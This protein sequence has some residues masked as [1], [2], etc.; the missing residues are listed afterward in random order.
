MIGDDELGLA[1]PGDHSRELP[2][3]PFARDRRVRDRR[4]A[5]LGDIIENVQDP[6]APAAGHLIVDEV[7]RPA[8]IRAGDPD[9]RRSRA[10]G[11]LTTP[12]TPDHEPLLAIEA[13]RSLAVEDQP[14]PAQQNVQAPVA[15]PAA[16]GGKLPHSPAQRSIVRS[17]TAIP[18]HAPVHLDRG[19]RPPLAHLVGSAQMSDGL[20]PGGG[21]HHF[22]ESR[23]FRATLSSMASARSFLSFVFSSSS[24]F[25][26]R[27]SGTSSPPNFA[28]QA[29]N[30][31]SLIPCRRHTSPV[32]APAS[33]SRRIAMIC[34]CVNLDRFV[35]RS[36]QGP[37][38]YPQMDEIA[39]VRSDCSG[40]THYPESPRRRAFD[41][42]Y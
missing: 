12:P 3:N 31:A 18:D 10:G 33:C 20:S 19:T 29:Y 26:R 6:E 9:E 34:S 40:P 23:S 39:G 14:L 25:S 8:G 11:P 28:F 13:L 16:F 30:V 1:A 17:P 27:A 37:G 15:E 36:F 2:S 22:F 5:L 32:F 38:L 35:V 24:A 7:N 21:R 41:E 4:Q 42:L